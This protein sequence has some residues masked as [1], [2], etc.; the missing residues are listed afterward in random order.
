MSNQ[1]RLVSSFV[2]PPRF[3][4]DPGKQ[5]RH[6]EGECDSTEQ[7]A[8][9]FACKG[10]DCAAIEGAPTPCQQKQGGRQENACVVERFSDCEHQC[11]LNAQCD[12]ES[13]QRAE[14]G[15]WQTVECWQSA[16]FPC[17]KLYLICFSRDREDRSQT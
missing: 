5:R 7:N 10:F 2:P 12:D 16:G 14:V 4:C 17:R 8:W 6:G 15:D 11:P 3:S 1:G 9:A 13:A